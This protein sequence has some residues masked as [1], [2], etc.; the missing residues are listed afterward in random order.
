PGCTE[1]FLEALNYLENNQAIHYVFLTYR[2]SKFLFGEH[3]YVYPDLPNTDPNTFFHRNYQVSSPEEARE[4][5]WKG[6]A[7][8]ITRL[9]AAGKIVYVLYPIP[10]IPVEFRKAI[11]PFSIFSSGTM[12]DLE[13]STEL[14]YYFKR[15]A[16][17]LDKLGSLPYGENLIAVNPLS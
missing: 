14:N 10:E 17:I 5:Y 3:P 12:I 4:L 9:Q 15:Q 7:D 2:H 11:M 13:K 1:W 8:T 6:F 16:Y